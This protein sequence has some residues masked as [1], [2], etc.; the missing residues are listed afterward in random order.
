MNWEMAS[1][2]SNEDAGLEDTVEQVLSVVPGE[3]RDICAPSA[4]KDDRKRISSMGVANRKR[5]M[6]GTVQ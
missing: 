5:G 3:L 1:W 6:F 4:H 2:V